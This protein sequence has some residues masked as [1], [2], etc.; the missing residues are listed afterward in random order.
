MKKTIIGYYPKETKDT[1]EYVRDEQDHYRYFDN[2]D[3]A[4][5]F[6][7]ERGVAEAEIASFVFR[8]STGQSCKRCGAPL[9]VSDVKGYTYQCF[10]CD[11]DF[12]SFEQ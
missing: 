2:I 3:N 1:L 4:K 10:D 9:F 5:N 12:Y 7:L 6:L 8:E 11:E